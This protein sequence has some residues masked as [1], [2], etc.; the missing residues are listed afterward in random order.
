Y[1]NRVV[2][3]SNAPTYSWVDSTMGSGIVGGAM[4]DQSAATREVG[5]IA[6]RVLGG[7]R[8]DSIPVTYTDLN[9]AQVDWRQLQRWNIADARVPVRTIVR[10]REPGIRNRYRGYISGAIAVLIG[11]A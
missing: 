2:A 4:K 1:L 5:R 7:E 10:F 9:V 8:A 11:Q 6:L 3:V